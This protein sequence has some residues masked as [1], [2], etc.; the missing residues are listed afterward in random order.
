VAG[1]VPA[2]ALMEPCIEFGLSTGKRRA[3]MF[4]EGFDCVDQGG[5]SVVAMIGAASMVVAG[6]MAVRPRFGVMAE[7]LMASLWRVRTGHALPACGGLTCR[8][9]AYGNFLRA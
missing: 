8:G 7:L 5:S 9:V 4:A 1:F 6:I 3:V 2:C